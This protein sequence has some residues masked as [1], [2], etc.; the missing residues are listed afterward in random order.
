MENKVL[1][2]GTVQITRF[3]EELG[4]ITSAQIDLLLG[5]N[6][7]HKDYY[8]KSLNRTHIKEEPEGVF[9]LKKNKG[10]N[11]LMYTKDMEFCSWVLLSNDGI[12]FEPGNENYYRGERPTQL[13]FLKKDTV[14][15][16]VYIDLNRKGIIQMLQ[17]KYYARMN[18]IDDDGSFKYVFVIDDEKTMDMLKSM[19]IVV[20][21]VVAHVRFTGADYPEVEYYV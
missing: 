2:I 3:I 8:I 15:N 10:R 4:G 19:Q 9:T 1:P 6:K 11:Q 20:P 13:F 16:L 7:K 14:Y 12:S 21:N 17:Q 5:E 18:T